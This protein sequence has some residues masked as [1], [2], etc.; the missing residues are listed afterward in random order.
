MRPALVLIVESDA[1]VRSFL[2]RLL[3]R[4]GYSIASAADAEAGLELSEA[5]RPDLVVFDGESP[6]V[7]VFEVCR[8]LR[9]VPGGGGPVL[10]CSGDASLRSASEA[11][12][13][14]A[15]GYVLKPFEPGAFL[16]NCRSLLE[17]APGGASGRGGYALVTIL[18]LTVAMGLMAGVILRSRLQATSYESGAVGRVAQDISD[19]SAFSS[20]SAAWALTGT[21]CASGAGVTCAGAGC[22]CTCTLASGAQVTAT[23]S[24]LGSACALSVS[25]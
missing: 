23:P 17:R 24:P 10:F 12:A 15:S 9:G 22:S 13:A 6:G 18:A 1:A 25:P 2:C 8:R 5:L 3:V 7:D 20:V 4:A 14:G 21:T 11:F 16:E 19:Q